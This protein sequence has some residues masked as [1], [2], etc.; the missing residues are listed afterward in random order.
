MFLLTATGKAESQT[1]LWRAVVAN[2]SARLEI[3]S[4]FKVKLNDL[5]LYFGA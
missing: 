5:N 1:K 4:Y 2:G 3:G